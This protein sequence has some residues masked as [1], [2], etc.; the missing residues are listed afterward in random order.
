MAKLAGKHFNQ[1]TLHF[2]D[3]SGGLNLI[4]PPEALADNE[5]QAVS[6]FEFSPDTGL[7]KVR[8]GLSHVCNF[9][10]PVTDIFPVAGSTSC[11][12]KAGS[13][14]WRLEA[15]V[16][17]MVGEVDG[18]KAGMYDY[19][20]TDGDMICVFGGHVHVYD[21]VANSLLR[22]ESMNCPTNANAIFYSSD[23]RICVSETGSD[24]IKLSGIGDPE[25]WANKPDDPKTGQ[26]TEVG[27]M[28][29]CQM[30]AMAPMVGEVIVFK[31][32]SGQTEHG[33]IYR[34]QG[35]FPDWNIV[36]YSQGAG[37]W[38]S[39][40]ATQ[41]GNDLMFLT[42]EGMAS[43]STAM[44]FGDYRLSWPG[45]KVNPRMA[46]TL[47][48]NCRLW[49]LAIKSQIWVWDGNNKYVYIYHYGI[50]NGAWTMFEFPDVVRACATV[51][52]NTFVGMG[53]D[54]YDLNDGIPQDILY[55]PE[56]EAN[57]IYTDIKAVWRPKTIIRRNQLL[58]KMIRANYLSTLPSIGYLD[59]EG[60][61]MELPHQGDG[62]IAEAD[63]D[64][65]FNDD[66]PLVPYR[67]R[68]RRRRCNFVRWDVTPQ[69]EVTN[70]LFSLS[71]IALEV[72]E[73]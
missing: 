73:V 1:E 35:K 19:F 57:P 11:L 70:G 42:R 30:T 20:D 56:D 22:V 63:P 9:P 28:D 49:Q 43:L 15:G 29:G 51:S 71:S 68:M 59:V 4:K 47:T 54:V 25:L 26:F 62:D 40:A 10:E 52:G 61:K 27:Y 64:V 60:M 23:G 24:V 39:N 67:T 38:N 44:E 5:M 17:F 41:V 37:A 66:D 65:A 12:V 69:I 72:A 50:G 34:L 8:G 14:L 21:R 18:D 16:R 53:N 3:F 6:N 13:T 48:T 36:L 33:K 58:T 2:S 45:V 55:N 46:Q 7:L 32:P 31:A